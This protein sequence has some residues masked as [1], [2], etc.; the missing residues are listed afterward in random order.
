MPGRAVLVDWFQG[1]LR[2]D[3][4]RFWYCLSSYRR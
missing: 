2:S 4:S 3:L 1:G